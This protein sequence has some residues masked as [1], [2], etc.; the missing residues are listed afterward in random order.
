MAVKNLDG[1]KYA[2]LVVGDGTGAGSNV[3]GYLGKDLTAGNTSSPAFSFDAFP[4]FS[5]GV[6]VG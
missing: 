3:T 5:G 1:D 6:F 2:D 4:G